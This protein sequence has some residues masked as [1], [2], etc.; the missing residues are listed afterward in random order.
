[1]VPAPALCANGRLGADW[2][3]G[4]Q[5]RLLAPQ[6]PQHRTIQTAWDQRP[7]RAPASWRVLSFLQNQK[8][9]CWAPPPPSPYQLEPGTA[10]TPASTIRRRTSST[11]FRAPKL[12]MSVMM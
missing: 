4:L 9:T 8:R 10:A 6:I 11:S 12:E 2:K 3:A 7:S 1:F 5:A